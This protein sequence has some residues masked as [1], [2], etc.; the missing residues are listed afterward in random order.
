MPRLVIIFALFSAIGILWASFVPLGGYND[1]WMHTRYA[2]AVVR[3]QI[4]VTDCDPKAPICGEIVC[5]GKC[6]IRV[7]ESI[8][9]IEDFKQLAFHP[10]IP[11]SVVKDVPSGKDGETTIRNSAANYPPLYYLLVGWPSLFLHGA[12]AWYAMRV[13]TALICAFFAVIIV[14]S[15]SS[16]FPLGVIL[17]FVSFLTPV[18]LTFFGAVNP[19]GPEIMSTGAL[20]ALVFPIAFSGRPTFR[21][22]LT[23]ALVLVFASNIRTPGV[24]WSFIIVLLWIILMDFAT[25][26]AVFKVQRWWIPFCTALLGVT[27][28][29]GWYALTKETVTTLGTPE[30]DATFIDT[31]MELLIS[32]KSFYLEQIIGM[33]GWNDNHIPGLLWKPALLFLLILVVIAFAVGTW[34]QRLALTVGAISFPIVMLAIQWPLMK[35]TGIMWVGR[36]WL[37]LV[38]AGGILTTLI[39]ASRG[40]YLRLTNIL[41]ICEFAG[42]VLVSGITATRRYAVGTLGTWNIT[43]YPTRHL[44][45]LGLFTVVVGLT[46]VIFLWWSRGHNDAAPKRGGRLSRARGSTRKPLT[47]RRSR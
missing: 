18:T 3:G 17:T 29:L 30:P 20:A 37:P 40:K 1:E 13:L 16:V 8:V 28:S 42:A 5:D 7:P 26:K 10:E 25:I 21:R 47:A 12:A 15:L 9:E 22:L 11:D 24:I 27:V 2:A 44:I 41:A 34:R 31:T 38:L 39:L 14:I 33:W 43:T 35:S 46:W 32:T 36:Y 19:Q 6:R 4:P 45:F 23:A